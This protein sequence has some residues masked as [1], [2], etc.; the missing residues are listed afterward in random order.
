[1]KNK[2]KRIFKKRNKLITFKGYEL[3]KHDENLI[4]ESD[5]L[6]NF[7]VYR[8]LNKRLNTW[9]IM[10]I[11]LTEGCIKNISKEIK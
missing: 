11:F 6:F 8:L 1:M 5:K 7:E 9:G 10:D 2:L 4:K 3:F